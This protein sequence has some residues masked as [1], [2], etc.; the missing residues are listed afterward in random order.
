MLETEFGKLPNYTLFSKL[1]ELLE[2]VTKHKKVLT[3]ALVASEFQRR[4][5]VGGTKLGQVM[6]VLLTTKMHDTNKI[7][8]IYSYD[9]LTT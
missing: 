6:Q 5:K 3:S 1:T 4:N 2:I 7:T 8:Y 9:Y